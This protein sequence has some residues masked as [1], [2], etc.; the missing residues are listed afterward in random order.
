MLISFDLA[1]TNCLTLLQTC[2]DR[3]T[4]VLNV[5]FF[6]SPRYGFA[7]LN[8]KEHLLI[9]VGGKSVEDKG[10]GPFDLNQGKLYLYVHSS[11][12]SSNLEVF[13]SVKLFPMKNSQYF[14]LI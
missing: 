3:L 9:A 2:N 14:L 11:F 12:V 7:L 6:F 10:E 5:L 1:E 13:G 8:F 4:F